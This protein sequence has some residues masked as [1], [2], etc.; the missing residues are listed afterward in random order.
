MS[1]SN[2]IHCN[3]CYHLYASKERKFYHLSCLH[4]LCKPCMAKT[5]RG[6]T[7]PLCKKPL[8]RFTELN[9]QMER[10]EKMFYN[11]GSLKMF[12]VMHQ[13]VIFQHKQ[14]EDMIRGILRRR[15]AIVQMK[16]MENVLREKIVETQRRYEKF[17]TYRRNLQETLRQVSPRYGS[18]PLIGH[19]GRTPLQQLTGN[20][21]QQ[22]ALP[23]R[24]CDPVSSRYPQKRRP[25]T[26]TSFP[27]SPSPSSTDFSFG[28]PSPS[29]RPLS[30]TNSSF[31]R[32][33]H[34]YTPQ[35]TQ[36]HFMEEGN[37]PA[38]TGMDDSGI[39]SMQTPTSNI[40]FSGSSR[41]MSSARMQ[42][43][44]PFNPSTP[45]R[46]RAG[47]SSYRHGQILPSNIPRH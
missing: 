9:D 26:V 20:R 42:Q 44:H 23:N 5:N 22:Q 40:S 43:Q 34:V 10:K 29:E 37:K 16:E 28:T 46:H 24:V 45:A 4:V 32:M 7:C 18:G 38:L 15:I 6:T 13:S 41:M 31:T 21:A 19:G 35:V 3:I 33:Q 2:W 14:R 27:S 17:R 39:S 8:E 47:T 36:G 1:T 12:S 11:P 30:D 25:N